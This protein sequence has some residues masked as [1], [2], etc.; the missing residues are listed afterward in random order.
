M[1]QIGHD[2]ADRDDQ[3]QFP[4]ARPA[5]QERNRQ[6]QYAE[7]KVVDAQAEG[8]G[9]NRAGVARH[10][11]VHAEAQRGGHGFHDDRTEQCQEQH[12]TGAEPADEGED[13]AGHGTDN[14]LRSAPAGGS[15]SGR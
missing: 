10:L 3:Q 7:I 15:A 4:H 5:K 13:V 14:R 8:Q 1:D 12:A 2:Q 6:Q 11:Q 9:A